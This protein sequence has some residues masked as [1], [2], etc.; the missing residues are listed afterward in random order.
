MPTLPCQLRVLQFDLRVLPMRTRFPFRYGIASLTA[1]PHLFVQVDLEI[2]GVPVRGVTSEGLPPKWFTKNP[3][4]PNELDLAAML[5]VIQNAVRLATVLGRDPRTWYDLA[6]EL[7]AEQRLWA[8]R[9]EHP[10]LLWHLGVSLVERALL[11]AICKHLHTPLHAAL[12]GPAL[13]IRWS[14]LHESLKDDEAPAFLAFPPANT[15]ALRHTVG[16]ADALVATEIPEGERVA[17]GLPQALDECI[18][19]YGLRYFKIK[20]SGQ[21]EP[22]RSRLAAITRLLVMHC[23]EQEQ[24]FQVTLDGN[25]NFKDISTFKAWY[26]ELRRDPD[27][28]PLMEAVLWV[29]Q[30]LHRD[31][32]LLPEV[33][34]TLPAWT[35]APPIIID[36]SD[37]DDGCAAQAL[38]LG[39]AGTSH[40]NCKGILKALENASFI[41]A[42]GGILSG[43]DLANVGPL[44]LT[45]D[46]AM[47]AILGV[48][49]V[50]RNGH[51]YF[52]GLSMYPEAVA[53]G[54]AELHPDLYHRTEDGLVTLKVDGGEIAIGSV[55]AAPF[56][57]AV[58]LSEVISS[59]PT[60]KEWILQGGM[61]ALEE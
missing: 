45:Q 37:G 25:E 31:Q 39:Y 47:Q 38:K 3:D 34:T 18:Q 1:L 22:D 53:D 35:S 57:S 48:R 28:Q 58:D 51:H 61:G 52:R 44:P 20:L 33:G 8:A 54:M 11:D 60:V 49:H 19:A 6:R 50:E 41:H 13:G 21:T 46:L 27:L 7:T 17:D 14:E 30:P 24:D 16:L 23:S 2:D 5:A 36:E 56:G 43:E 12:R 9:H 42:V 32:A 4:T 40:K 59:L 10:P 26:E 15:V 55:N 29:E